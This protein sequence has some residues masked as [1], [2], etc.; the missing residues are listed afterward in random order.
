MNDRTPAKAVTLRDVAAHAGVSP[1]TVSNV[2]N[3]FAHVSPAMRTKVQASIEALRYRPN[4]L[5]RSLRQ[6]RTGHILLLVPDL[7]VAYFAELAHEVVERAGELGTTVMVDETGGDAGRERAMLDDAAESSWVDGVLLSSLGLGSTDLDGMDL[8][9]MSTRM[10]VVL[11]GERTASSSLDH[12]GIDNVAAAHAATTHLIECGRTRVVALGGNGGPIDATSQ[13]RLDGFNRAMT[14]AGLPVAG[15]HVGT[16]DY[17]RE[18]A[19]AVVTDLMDGPE[20]PDALFCFSDDLACGALRALYDLGIRVP[21]DV[22]VAGFDDAGVSAYLTPGL[23]SIRQD[24]TAIARSALEML[25]E[26]KSG[27]EL[28]PRDVTVSYELVVRE[29]TNGAAVTRR[30]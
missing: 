17:S 6:G 16:P 23:T 10:P 13:L 5:A 18:S 14:A 12:V 22:A 30:S 15:R 29:S 9:G 27:H 19:R 8:A 2:V 25:Y 7:T 1:R 3:G 20:P 11:L 24:R 21:T 28:P 4:L 26:R